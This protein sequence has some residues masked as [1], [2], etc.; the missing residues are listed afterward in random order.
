MA[1]VTPEDTHKSVHPRARR[2]IGAPG[3]ANGAGERVTVKTGNAETLYE[4][5]IIVYL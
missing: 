2:A 1:V 5:Y 3:T 4:K